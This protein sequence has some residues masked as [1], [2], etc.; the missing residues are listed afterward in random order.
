MNDGLLSFKNLGLVRLD[1]LTL[2]PNG[3]LKPGGGLICYYKPCYTCSVIYDATYCTPDLEMLSIK[4]VRENHIDI[5]VSTI[6]RPPSGSISVAL[7]R[8]K[9]SCD[10][11]CSENNNCDL[12]LL[13]DL[14]LNLLINNNYTKI[15]SE[16]CGQLS[17]YNLVNIPTR[18][19]R[20][21]GTSIDII[22]TNCHKIVSSG[23]VEYNT[24]DHLLLYSV[25]KHTKVKDRRIKS[26]VRTYK[27]YDLDLVKISLD[28]YNWGRFYARV[29]V[30]EAWEELYKQ[31]LVVADYFAPYIDT[32][33]RGNQPGW[34][35]SAIIE[36]SIE[37]DR[38]MAIAKRSTDE[39]IIKKKLRIK[40]MK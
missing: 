40:E 25:K 3:D 22:V 2:N 32:Y 1:R 37:R 34:L 38:L 19:T 36:D 18:V 29:D 21:C 39:N 24:S 28:S 27:N 20:T 31:I 10:F 7:E 8:I 13:G 26:K 9:T 4:L 14:N 15:F 35:T 23:V 33:I 12:Y 5:I 30:E 6:Y 16:I 11:L 17:L